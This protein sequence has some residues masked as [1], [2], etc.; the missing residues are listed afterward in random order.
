MR[1]GARLT[2]EQARHLAIDAQGLAR[3]RPARADARAL[4]AAI[5]TVEVLQLDAINVLERTQFLVPFARVGAYDVGRLHDL[6][7][8]GGE[9]FEY[10]AHAASLVPMGRHPLLRWRMAQAGSPDDGSAYSARRRAFEVEHADYIAAGLGEV[11]ERGALAASQLLDPRRRNG[12]W[13]QRRSLGRVALEFLFA[14]GDLAAWR[15]TNFERIYD[16]PERVIPVDVLAAPTPDVDEA[17]R[18]LILL[19]ARAIG[20]G[21]ISDLANYYSLK[22]KQAALRV[23]EL[24]AKGELVEVAVDGWRDRA[25]AL[26][27]AKVKPVRRTDAAFLSPFDS[28][29][30]ERARTRRLF[31]FDY[32]IEVYTPAP[33]RV[34]GYYVLPMLLGDELVGRFDLKADRQASALRVQAAHIE[35]GADAARVA[36]AAAAELDRMRGWLGLDDIAVARR[37]NLATEL[38][39]HVHS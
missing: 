25:Y 12:E 6:T 5:D 13:W 38:R 24:V 29:I 18:E 10:W 35:S 21:S 11:R 7:G 32:R 27:T 19:S 14:R 34:Y 8:P 1:P 4:R 36:N 15:S 31:G 30:W 17:Q 26:A 23:A 39:K 2:I 20:V 3:P 37:G 33:K 28:L 22:T 9:L 16:L